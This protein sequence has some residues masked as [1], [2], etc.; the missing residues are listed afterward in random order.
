[1]KV[2]GVLTLAG[3]GTVALPTVVDYRFSYGSGR[4]C[5]SCAL[6]C[7]LEDW[8]NRELLRQAVRVTVSAGGVQRFFGV[9]DE[10]VL[11]ESEK[12][13]RLEVH[14]RSMAALL[15]DNE[16]GEIV[17]PYATWQDILAGH[18]TPYGLRVDCPVSLPPVADFSVPSGSSEWDV[19]RRFCWEYG[20]QRLR[21]DEQGV[22]RIGEAST[23]RVVTVS[24]A[25]PVVRLGYRWKRYGCVSE[26]LA[27]E[28]GSPAGLR[29]ENP[30]FLALGGR[31][32]KRIVLPKGSG[33]GERVR[34]ARRLIDRS[35]EE[36]EV[37]EVALPFAFAAGIG[38][39]VDLA[40]LGLRRKVV[41]VRVTP[42]R[43]EILLA[44]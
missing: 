8:G 3:G 27:F 30:G 34:A 18:V 11:E 29:V 42:T 19:L 12:G 25:S 21:V 20:G 37:L 17:Y 6:T 35:M 14:G 32:R 28:S 15:L 23:G 40:Q 1:L 33:S 10:I 22:L 2:T 39:L 36:A 9:V 13:R 16:A 31:S 43:S 44:P 41:G 38:D 7:L 24:E 4:A 5:D 26:V